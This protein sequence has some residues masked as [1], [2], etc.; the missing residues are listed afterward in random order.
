MAKKEEITF[1]QNLKMLED[2]VLGLQKG[3]LPLDKSLELFEQGVGLVKECQNKLKKAE[4]KVQ[5][6]IEDNQGNV[7]YSDFKE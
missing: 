2:I 3:D 1:E 7:E 6:L 5:V 4:R